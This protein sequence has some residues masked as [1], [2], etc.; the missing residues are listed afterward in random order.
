M[1]TQEVIILHA[2][3]FGWVDVRNLQKYLEDKCCTDCWLFLKKAPVGRVQKTVDEDTRIQM[4][5]TDDS[6]KSAKAY[7]KELSEKEIKVQMMAL[8]K[9]S[10]RSMN[11]GG[12]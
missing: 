4:R 5:V 2:E 7:Y 11:R 6:K 9:V 1:T 10:D 12:C 8:E 3:A